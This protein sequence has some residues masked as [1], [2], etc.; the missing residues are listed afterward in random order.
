[1]MDTNHKVSQQI[2]DGCECGTLCTKLERQDLRWVDPDGR[3]P[4]YVNASEMITKTKC[5]MTDPM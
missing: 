3:H 2:G 4:T 1:M 5:I